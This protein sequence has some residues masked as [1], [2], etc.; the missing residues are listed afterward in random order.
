MVGA[1]PIAPNMYGKATETAIAAMTRLAEVY[2]D[3]KSRLSA[4]DIADN[5]RLA[6]PFVG[7]IL[8]T[9]SQAGLVIGSRGP[10]GGFTLS[11]HPRDIRLVEIFRLF[12]REDV[13]NNCPFGGGTCGMGNP[14][15]LHDKLVRVR[16]E[17]DRVLQGTTLEEFRVA[18]QVHG[19]RP[20]YP[21]ESATPV[22]KRESFRALKSS[23]STGRRDS[24]KR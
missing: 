12:E 2:E 19:L 11:R 10:G 3:G 1:A 20:V 9:L 14:C 7:K 5:R 8:T 17:M 23:G 24:R 18:Y 6:R 21:G 16:E 13:S 15:S 4:V 22:K